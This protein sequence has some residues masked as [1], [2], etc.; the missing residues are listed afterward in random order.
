[1]LIWLFYLMLKTISITSNRKLGG[2]AATYRSGNGSVYNTCPNE[3]PLKP[4]IG[5]GSSEIDQEYLQ[6]VID[7]V[8][9]G[10]LSWTYTHFTSKQ[11]MRL[12][13]R[14]VLGKTVINISA[15]TYTD[16]VTFVLEGYP[17]VVSVPA[18]FDSKVDVIPIGPDV[19]VKVVRCPAEY[20]E[21]V[22]CRNCGGGRPLC[23]R[24]NRD[25]IIK[26]TA[27]GNA[28]KKVGTEV[29]GGCYGSGGPVAIHWKKTMTATQ[30]VSDIEK[31]NS[32]IKT[33]PNGTFVRH[34]IVGDLGLQS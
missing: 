28:A 34:H 22:T 25:Y 3:C 14:H 27:H 9:K 23:A 12:I 17:T 11:S 24:G 20:N 10:G 31:L 5:S 32:W 15:D 8:P 30:E 18:S 4:D 7:A 29:K 2:C 16:A 33:L 1:M 26:F 6:A 19:S 21:N 13:P